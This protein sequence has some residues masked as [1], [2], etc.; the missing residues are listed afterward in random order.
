M[1]SAWSEHLKQFAA[2]NKC[3]YKEAMS[4]DK[5]KAAYAKAREALPKKEKPPKKSKAKKDTQS[6]SKPSPP[7]PKEATLAEP[8]I[9]K[10]TVK[11]KKK[12]KVEPTLEE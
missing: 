10:R 5:S 9:K 12:S 11:R 6:Q 2:A 4:N 7:E 8:L 1:P 3:T